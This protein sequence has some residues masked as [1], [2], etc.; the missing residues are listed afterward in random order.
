MILRSRHRKRIHTPKASDDEVCPDEPDEL[1][2]KDDDSE[3]SEPLVSRAK[4]FTKKRTHS[5]LKTCPVTSPEPLDD[6]ATPLEVECVELTE[7]LSLEEMDVLQPMTVNGIT[8]PD[9]KQL[10]NFSPYFESLLMGPFAEKDQVNLE[11]PIAEIMLGPTTLK[12]SLIY[13]H[14]SSKEATT[15]LQLRCG[16]SP[17]F[18]VP[19]KIPFEMES[20]PM[21]WEAD[22]KAAVQYFMTSM[23]K[24]NDYHQ[25]SGAEKWD[26]WGNLVLYWCATDIYPLWFVEDVKKAC[27]S[28]P[29]IYS[30]AYL[31][32]LWRV[33]QKIKHPEWF[34]S[35]LVLAGEEAWTHD[36][37]YQAFSAVKDDMWTYCLENA[38]MVIAWSHH[39]CQ[40]ADFRI[41]EGALFGTAPK[42]NWMFWFNLRQMTDGLL[43][44]TKWP[45]G[46]ILAGGAVVE[47]CFGNADFK[48]AGR[49]VD[50][51]I[52]D[53]T[54]A[55]PIIRELI[56]EWAEKKPDL[57][58]WKKHKSVDVLFP[59]CNFHIQI[60]IRHLPSPWSIIT[61]F[62]FDYVRAF[63]GANK[64]VYM[65]P[66][67]LMAWETRQVRW[68]YPEAR[69]CLERLEKARLKGFDVESWQ[70]AEK[71]PKDDKFQNLPWIHPRKEDPLS[72]VKALAQC[73][74]PMS[75]VMTWDKFE[76]EFK[77]S[78]YQTYI[79]D[80]NYEKVV[81][82]DEKMLEEVLAS[83]CNTSDPRLFFR[84]Y[85]QIYRE[86]RRP[87]QIIMVLEP[88]KYPA[89]LRFIDQI[90]QM[91]Q[92]GYKKWG[93]KFHRRLSEYHGGKW[94]FTVWADQQ[95]Q[96]YDEDNVLL[97]TRAEQ[98]TFL[99]SLDS[100]KHKFAEILISCPGVW[101]LIP[102]RRGQT[103]QMGLAY[104]YHELR[105]YDSAMSAEMRV[106][107]K[108]QQVQITYFNR[109]PKDA[110]NEEE[111]Q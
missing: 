44:L 99:E 9:R 11:L 10:C 103:V 39:Y 109:I 24:E 105:L 47:A 80:E 67:C 48:R 55:E 54:L 8:V 92:A 58:V 27:R 26:W 23:Q 60:L 5:S 108:M 81:N 85:A 87:N 76:K 21:V 96:V 1:K 69:T 77:M 19:R 82:I 106:G 97:E 93:K 110:K 40:V 107:S 17:L 43:P 51:W 70:M 35:A 73:V 57:I 102:Q 62:D 34:A 83:N 12:N 98:Q 84:I 88:Q 2:I 95:C 53:D 7:S 33:L 61:T 65:L 79:V 29:I 49:D 4:V 59:G 15:T 75:E 37:W 78:L 90:Q 111:K 42:E 14:T 56:A 63:V 3:D 30:F 66:E 32:Q 71:V 28:Y 89:Q 25:V 41:L 104:R 36:F 50:L 100:T 86:T 18:E 64:T 6:H 101:K 46:V 16:Y 52:W 31:Q 68:I 72:Y 13:E 45:D 74:A 20:F 22:E 94:F 91:E 38:D